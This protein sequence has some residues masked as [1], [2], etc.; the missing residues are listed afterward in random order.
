MDLSLFI[1]IHQVGIPITA[2]LAAGY[3]VFLTLK[4][5]LAGATNNVNSIADIIRSLDDRIEAMNTQLYK[6][7]VKVT[8]SLGL[9]PDFT[10]LSR[11]KGDD[12]RVD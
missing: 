9:D 7:D 1:F 10:R 5:I 11:T 3:F 6:I 4:F 12:I 8:H 2:A